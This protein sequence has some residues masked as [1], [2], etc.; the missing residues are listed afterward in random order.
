MLYRTLYDDLSETTY[1]G[2]EE[3]VNALFETENGNLVHT[4]LNPEVLN[5]CR[6]C[7]G[8]LKVNL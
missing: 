7:I 1:F 4:I 6:F 5:V 3:L 2:F 8:T